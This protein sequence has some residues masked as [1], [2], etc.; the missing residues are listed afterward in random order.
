MTKELPQSFNP[1]DFEESIYQDWIKKGYFKSKI[2]PAKKPYTIV[3]PPPNVTGM[4][5]MGHILNNTI[6]DILIR[7]HRMDGREACWVPGTDHA[8]I[9]TEAKVTKMLEERGIKKHEIGRDKFL[10]YAWEWKEKYGGI[11]ITQLKRMGASCDWDRERFTM[12]E[13]YYKAVIHSFVELY[14]KG[15]IYRGYRLVNWCPVSKSA[16]SDEE[17]YFKEDKGKLYFFKYPIKDSSETLIIATTRP[18]TL[19]GDTAIAVNPADTRYKD[20]IGKKVILPIVNREIPVIG[21]EYVDMEFGTGALKVTPAHDANDYALGLKHDLKVINIFNPD[22]TLNDNA[23]E[24]FRGL[25]RFEA[26]EAVVEKMRELK[27]LDKI[28]EYTHNVGYSE[29]GH[30]PIEPFLSEQWYMKMEELSKPAIAAVKEGKISFY[31]DRWVKTYFHW[32]EN[33][34]DWCISRQLW[35]GHRIPVY[36][37]ENCGFYDAYEVAPDKCPKC[38]STKIRQDEDVLDTWASSWL[39]PFAVH[40]W[41]N[42]DK[43]IDYYYPT[44]TLVTAPDIIFFWVARMIIAGYEFKGD[45]PF[46]RV[47]FTGIIRDELGRKM[48]KSLGNSPDPLDVMAEFG[49]DALRYT[50]TRLAPLGNDIFYSNEKCELGRNFANKIWNASRYILQNAKGV[51]IVPLEKVEKDDF[52]KWILHK[53]NRLIRRVRESLDAFRFN[54]MTVDLYDFIWSEFCDWYIEASK[55]KMYQ[56]DEK[57]KQHKQSILIGVLEGC[58]KLLHPVMPFV[59]ERIYQALP[60]TGESIMIAEYPKEKQAF[61]F[62]A[63]E[64]GIEWLKAMIYSVRNIRGENSIPPNVGVATKIVL[65]KG[66]HKELLQNNLEIVYKLAK[67]DS[68]EILSRHQKGDKEIAGIGGGFEIFISIEGL[69]DVE[70]ER[71]RMS[72][73]IER[74]SKSIAG[75]KSK[76]SNASFLDKAPKDVVEKEN[77]KLRYLETELEKFKRN[78]ESLK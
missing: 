10:E 49:A 43:N 7:Y 64:Q 58:L 14:K 37:C 27:Y 4:L 13:G 69:I 25:D 35:W 54:D 9:A 11:I 21:D 40:D 44:N 56:G 22:A 19:L 15:Y 59:T 68:M 63:E 76:L 46:D 74:M 65:E 26:R 41:P 67:V 70:K 75:T 36:Y 78:L 17:V 28:E 53:Y 5:H 16:I 8:S 30:V 48:S 61:E 33:V 32:M 38:G 1:A 55:I 18:E 51:K 23:P 31:P 60:G 45:I 34:K 71:E 77:E 24:E 2:D 20:V 50:I 42:K 66:E 62:A 73:E 39:W 57:Q 47:Y 29:R 12:D 3:I 72:K 6:Q 52:D